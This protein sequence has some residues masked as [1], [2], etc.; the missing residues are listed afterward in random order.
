MSKGFQEIFRKLPAHCIMRLDLQRFLKSFLGCLTIVV[1][2]FAEP[3]PVICLVAATADLVVA[4]YSGS[5]T[6]KDLIGLLRRSRKVQE[7][8]ILA[9]MIRAAQFFH[10]NVFFCKGLKSLFRVVGRAASFSPKSLT[11]HHP[12]VVFQFFRLP[13]DKLP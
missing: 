13:V 8:S 9:Q 3:D 5:C 11:Q 2:G 1:E 10:G 4:R 7:K 6:P 12:A